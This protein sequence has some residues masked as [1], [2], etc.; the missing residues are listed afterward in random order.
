[1]VEKLYQFGSVGQMWLGVFQPASDT[2]KNV[3]ED[4]GNPAVNKQASQGAKIPESNITIANRDIK[5]YD[6]FAQYS[7]Q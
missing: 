2:I 5:I 1:M 4:N 7:Y 6:N 3:I